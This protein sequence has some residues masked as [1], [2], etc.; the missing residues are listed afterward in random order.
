MVENERKKFFLSLLFDNII[1]TRAEL[2][3]MSG[4][5]RTKME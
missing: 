4:Q 5:E 1:K 3:M 2:Q